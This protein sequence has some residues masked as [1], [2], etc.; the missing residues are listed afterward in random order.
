MLT[1]RILSNEII[2]TKKSVLLLGPRQTGKSTLIRSLNPDIEINL[3]DQETFI[4]HISDPGLIK[5]EIKDHKKIF[6]DEIQRI[7]SLLNTIQSLIDHNPQLQFL[8][9]GSS[10]RKLKRGQANLLPGRVLGYELAPLTHEELGIDFD[11]NKAMQRGLL[12]GIYHEK[13]DVIAHKILKTYSSTYLK[14]EIQAEALTRDIE[15]FARYFQVIASRS[16]N[17]IDFSK[18]SSTAM[19]ERT[20]ARR[21][22]DVLTDTMVI[23]P[24]EPFTQSKRRRL[25]QHPKYYFF[26]VGVLNGS[27]DNFGV[28]FDRVGS[29]F[30]HLFLQLVIS[31]AK[32]HDDTIRVS[33]YRTE[34][35]A[36]V[37]FIIEK[38]NELFAIEVKATK[39]IGAHDLT[40]LKSFRDFYK[41]KHTPIVAYLGEKELDYDGIIVCSLLKAL[42][43]L[44]Y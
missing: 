21:Y 7:P 28:S 32:A 35:G 23:Y 39:K 41:K 1:K 22:F 3:A 44:G 43:I 27:L 15:G 16:G 36:E 34:A 29:L 12:P 8:L 17:F 37:D 25:V 24:V 31:S 18:F 6:I 4:Q 26:D 5:R 40:G 14:E 20:T 42:S 13:S 11:E 38:K 30:E 33:V 9:T 19:I 10:A 2:D